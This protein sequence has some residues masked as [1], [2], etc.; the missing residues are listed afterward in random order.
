M[1]IPGHLCPFDEGRHRL[2]PWREKETLRSGFS[3]VRCHKT[4]EWQ[5]DVLESTWPD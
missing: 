3:C 1:I 5:G 2:K 4:W